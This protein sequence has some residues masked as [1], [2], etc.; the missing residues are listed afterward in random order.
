MSCDYSQIELS[1][2]RGS[3]RREDAVRVS[4]WFDIHT[5]TAAAIWDIPPDEVTK[6][7][8][9]AAKAVNF[10]VIYG[11]GPVGLS[12]SAGIP[13]ADAKKFIAAY[14]ETYK[15]IKA[16][17]DET[18]AKAHALGYVES[19]FGRRRPIPDINSGL[20]QLRAAAERMATNMPVQGTSADLLKLAMIRISA[21]L[22][23]ISK[24]ARLLL[25][26]HDELVLEIPP[27]ETERVARAIRDIMENVDKDI[28]S[29]RP[30][31]V[32]LAKAGAER[33]IG[34][35]IVVEAKRG[36]NWEEMKG[37]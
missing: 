22:P 27:K 4:V 12:Q 10:G 29:S 2:D 8:R 25:Q 33:G 35:P 9:R 34:A 7:Q 31:A 28:L 16:W 14:F 36:K 32:A 13:F 37:V 15:G 5:A 1:R 23:E 21:E 11:Q 3:R 30:S 20:P 6:D 24:S 19:L 17:L 18:K 26:V